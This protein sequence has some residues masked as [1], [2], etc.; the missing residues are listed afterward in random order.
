MA[1]TMRFL[2]LVEMTFGNKMA[3]LQTRPHKIQR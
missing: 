1:S 3:G 2:P